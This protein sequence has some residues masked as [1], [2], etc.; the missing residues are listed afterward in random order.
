MPT[1]NKK[2]VHKHYFPLVFFTDEERQFAIMSPVFAKAYQRTAYAFNRKHLPAVF[3]AF[4]LYFLTA[5]DFEA[6]YS[7]YYFLY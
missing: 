1:C 2:H 5:F 4:T 7:R 6:T 3:L